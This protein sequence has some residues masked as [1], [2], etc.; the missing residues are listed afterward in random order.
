VPRERRL[1]IAGEGDRIVPPEHPAALAAHW[2]TTV[3]WFPGGHLAQLG[4]ER[5]LSRLARFAESRRSQGC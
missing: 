5:A 4:R 2:Q 3:E 1:V